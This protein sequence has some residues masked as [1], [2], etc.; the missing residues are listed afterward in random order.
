MVN[1]EGLFEAPCGVGQ[2]GR[3]FT[4][5]VYVAVVVVAAAH[6]RVPLVAVVA[7]DSGGGSSGCCQVFRLV[8]PV[9]PVPATTER[10]ETVC[11][12]GLC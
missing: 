8:L 5:A 2:R 12:P 11:L 7:A 10:K 9:L 4:V 1:A 6:A 3:G